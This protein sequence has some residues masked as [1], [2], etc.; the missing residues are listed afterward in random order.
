MAEY[1]EDFSNK[2]NTNVIAVDFGYD[3]QGIFYG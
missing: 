2:L 3:I 1:T